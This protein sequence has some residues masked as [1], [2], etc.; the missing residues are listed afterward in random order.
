MRI[1]L[2]IIFLFS[3]STL[4][5]A[6]EL[7][8]KSERILKKENNGY[9]I[10]TSPVI[11]YNGSEKLLFVFSNTTE[12]YGDTGL[13]CFDPLT[14]DL[15]WLYNLYPNIDANP[16]YDDGI[17]Y[18]PGRD[19]FYAIYSSN[20]TLKWEYDS[21]Y[22]SYTPLIH[23]NS[24]FASLSLLVSL[25]KESGGKN[26]QSIVDS[27]YQPLFL[28][29]FLFVVDYYHW[30]TAVN[31]ANG[32]T[33]WWGYSKLVRTELAPILWN[34]YIYI[35]EASNY[36]GCSKINPKDGKRIWNYHVDNIRTSPYILNEKIY[37][38]DV[39][40]YLYC[41]DAND[42]SFKWKAAVGDTVASTITSAYDPVTQK[43]VLYF[44]SNLDYLHARDAADGKHLWVYKT[45]GNIRSTPCVSDSI[46]Y[47]TSDDGYLYAVNIGFKDG[48]NKKQS[49]HH[50]PSPSLS[51]YPNPF[52]D[53]LIIETSD[54]ARIYSITGQFIMK[55]EKGK[56]SI[57]TSS[58][59][60]GVYIVKSGT[61]TKRIVKIN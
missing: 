48:F 24:I 8:W 22:E 39:D 59:K 29:N 44:G 26:W 25:N 15:K 20:H 58:W 47:F 19:F 12:G 41:L 9:R 36:N 46:I 5:G 13:L 14:G 33:L 17:I 4:H 56:H 34:N 50:L 1:I 37:F 3:F 49:S 18:A 16:V 11:G 45:G 2:F 43:D 6:G 51:S 38:G 7:I 32:D 21:P 30:L 61:E 31:A 60:Q 23:S 54:K 27:Y 40:G 28:E 42:G 57:D 55:V 53:R 52:R 35:S 10:Q